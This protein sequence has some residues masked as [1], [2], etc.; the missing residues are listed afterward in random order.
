ML[1]NSAVFFSKETLNGNLDRLFKYI[2]ADFKK[3]LEHTL[4]GCLYPIQ[5]MTHSCVRSSF[6]NI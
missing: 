3:I 5:K 2:S 4:S 1:Y 6:I